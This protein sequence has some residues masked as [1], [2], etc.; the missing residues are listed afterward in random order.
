MAAVIGI[1]ILLGACAA[2]WYLLPRN[3][4]VHPL[5]QAPFLDVIIPLMLVIN[6]PIAVA[7][8]ILRLT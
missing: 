4:V 6:V 7:L 3:G 8:I 5:M 1:L 2:F